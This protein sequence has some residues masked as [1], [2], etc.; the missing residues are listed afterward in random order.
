M[1]WST[2]V[3][4]QLG[5]TKDGFVDSE[6]I[7]RRPANWPG[8]AADHFTIATAPSSG[9]VLEI[10]DKIGMAHEHIVH[11]PI[12]IRNADR[13]QRPGIGADLHLHPVGVRKRV[14]IHFSAVGRGAPQRLRDPGA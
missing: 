3:A 10:A 6:A 11:A 7:R 4:E 13:D 2:I 8:I 1:R 5:R 12:S 14:D 9:I